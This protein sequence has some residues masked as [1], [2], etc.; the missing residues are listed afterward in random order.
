M[1]ASLKTD[2]LP[3]LLARLRSS[4]KF[5]V[6]LE[7]DVTGVTRRQFKVVRTYGSLRLATPWMRRTEALAFL[8]GLAA[9]LEG[10]R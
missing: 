2:P 4:A 3:G 5:G 6:A 9:A 10:P 1:N 7:R 8:A